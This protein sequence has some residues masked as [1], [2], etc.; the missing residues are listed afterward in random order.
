[1]GLADKGLISGSSSEG[2]DSTPQQGRH[3]PHRLRQMRETAVRVET[4]S[5]GGGSDGGVGGGS[6]GESVGEEI[7]KKR[8]SERGGRG[9]DA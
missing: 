6:K 3:G 4:A 9:V 5:R 7:E 1:M 8:E 2:L